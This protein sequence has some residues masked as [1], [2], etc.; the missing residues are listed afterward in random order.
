MLVVPFL[1]GLMLGSFLNVCIHRLPKGNSIVSPPS[2]CPQCKNRLLLRDLIPV[3]S[4][5]ILGGRCRFC[6][7]SISLRYPLIELL[8]GVLFALTAYKLGYSLVTI[9]ALILVSALIVV[10]FVDMDHYIIPGNVL[11]F[12][13]I[14]WLAFLPF[15][16][17]DYLNSLVGLST[18]GGLL[19]LIALVSRG[20]MGMGD[21]KLAAVLGLY[22][23]W[24]N[25]LLAMFIACLLAGTCGMFLILFK[26]KSR[27][28]IIPF[29]PFIALASFITLLWG[30][31]IL[32]WYIGLL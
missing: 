11:I 12:L 9:Q 4:F 10:A 7:A 5:L 21:I 14:A 32:S 2:T 16:S 6:Q 28:D 26:I 20:G 23:G 24:P 22:L 25:A 13:L 30:D 17:V 27:K 15:L 31:R 8:T 18:A 3:I 1:Y 19:L 29:A